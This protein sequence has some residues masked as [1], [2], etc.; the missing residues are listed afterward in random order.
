MATKLGHHS[1]E[2]CGMLACIPEPLR[3]AS[4]LPRQSGCTTQEIMQQ[5]EPEQQ[6]YAPQESESV[7]S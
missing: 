2:M 5:E 3:R 6:T 7:R 1:F 4:G